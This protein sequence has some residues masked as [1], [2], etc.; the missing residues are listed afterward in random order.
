[1][2]TDYFTR[3]YEGVPHFQCA[4]CPF[5]SFDEVRMRAHITD[6]HPSPPEGGVNREPVSGEAP[7]EEQAPPWG[8]R[9]FATAEAPEPESEPPADEEAPEPESEPESEPPADEEQKADRKAGKS[10]RRR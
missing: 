6:R 1:M 2:E 5:D 10:E 8:D 4:R 7:A 9:R 3:D